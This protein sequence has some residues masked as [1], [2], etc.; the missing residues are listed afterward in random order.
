MWWLIFEF[1]LS[2]SF[3][4]SCSTLDGIT[5]ARAVWQQRKSS[6]TS[7]AAAFFIF[8][9]CCFTF[10]PRFSVSVLLEFR[11]YRRRLKPTTFPVFLPISNL[12][13]KQTLSF[14]DAKWAKWPSR[15]SDE[16]WNVPFH[17]PQFPFSTQEKT[18]QIQSKPLMRAEPWGSNGHTNVP[19]SLCF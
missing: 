6:F 15:L 18:H 2:S 7:K 12:V 3:P 17:V 1:E 19:P 13:D 4:D 11:V 8:F 16:E 9:R 10:F 5:S 14:S